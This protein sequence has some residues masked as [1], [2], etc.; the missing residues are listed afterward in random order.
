MSRFSSLFNRAA[1]LLA[2][3]LSVAA[4]ARAQYAPDA[5][6]NYYQLPAEVSI[7]F[8]APVVLNP[9]YD[10]YIK[11]GDAEL[12]GHVQYRP[13]TFVAFDDFSGNDMELTFITP[14][15]TEADGG[16]CLTLDLTGVES[17]S[18]YW[19]VYI[20]HH[21]LILDGEPWPYATYYDFSFYVGEAAF[22]VGDPASV[23]PRN[24]YH[25]VHRIDDILLSWGDLY[26]GYGDSYG[27][28]AEAAGAIRIYESPNNTF[29]TPGS[30]SL[31][32]TLTAEEF[33]PYSSRFAS[34]LR[35]TPSVALEDPDKWYT[36][37]IPAG[38][39]TFR[40][41]DGD[42]VEQT[43]LIEM[44]YTVAGPG[45]PIITPYQ[46]MWIPYADY[47]GLQLRG[48]D[49]TVR[50]ASLVAIYEGYYDPVDNPIEEATPLALGTLACA[51]ADNV[52]ITFDDDLPMY[53]G[54]YTIWIKPGALTGAPAQTIE[55]AITGNPMPISAV[56][57]TVRPRS[58]SRLESIDR[59]EIWWG[60]HWQIS[61]AKNSIRATMEKGGEVT[62]VTFTVATEQ[63]P[64]GSDDG[65]GGGIGGDYDY[66]LV[67]TPE[68]PI[69]APGTYT[70]TLP[71]GEVNVYIK[72][73]NTQGNEPVE[74]VYF[75]EGD[76]LGVDAPG[77][78]SDEGAEYY[79]LQGRRVAR[80][81][82]GIYIRVAGGKAGKRVSF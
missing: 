80:P 79:D 22:T 70:F 78:E 30:P 47:K 5:N 49:V 9:D 26:V 4:T 36:L 29:R 16:S 21:Y 39:F 51:D 48:G 54:G 41:A 3:S 1:A 7:Y 34:R 43:Q 57:V 65:Q 33:M 56:P 76:E 10:P 66:T 38:T 13:S 60:G 12:D 63:R 61:K 58:G 42:D 44:V 37:E 74:F 25:Q 40:N 11:V 27:S 52:L 45:N 19:Y 64:D 32:V 35:L 68:T 59:V 82:S 14:A 28:F 15:I 62:P 6:Q 69:T 67:W 77:A 20:P 73:D 72:S 24:T 75:I 46:N 71:A 50:D 8:D 2:L 17:R 18:G 81:G 55:F 23:P 53:D 31:E